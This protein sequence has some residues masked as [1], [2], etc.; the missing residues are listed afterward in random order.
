MANIERLLQDLQSDNPQKRFDACE[1]LFFTLG[2]LDNAIEALRKATKDSDPKFA[3]M[4]RNCIGRE[5]H[6]IPISCVLL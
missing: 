4:A 2:I 1:R 5:Y 3:E 6:V